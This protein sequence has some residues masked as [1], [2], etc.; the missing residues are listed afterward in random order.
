MD[1]LAKPELELV[2]SR[3]QNKRNVTITITD[4]NVTEGIESFTAMIS[5]APMSGVVVSITDPTVTIFIE[6]D[7]SKDY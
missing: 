3:D 7:D 6:D 4:D 1:F 5:K 2:F